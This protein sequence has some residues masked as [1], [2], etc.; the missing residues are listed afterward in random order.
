M[1]TDQEGALWNF[2]GNDNILDLPRDLISQVDVLL[3]TQ[4]NGKCKI[5]I[6]YFM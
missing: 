5:C 2:L 6:F 3:R 1:G 4:K